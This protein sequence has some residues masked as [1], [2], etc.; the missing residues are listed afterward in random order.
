MEE[1]LR[2]FW[3]C[4][5]TDDGTTNGGWPY[6]QG[7]VLGMVDAGGLLGGEEGETLP[8]SALS[9]V[10]VGGVIRTLEPPRSP[11]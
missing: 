2:G 9:A 4:P 7:F 5:L 10:I 3:P 1:G 11:L 6:P 8:L